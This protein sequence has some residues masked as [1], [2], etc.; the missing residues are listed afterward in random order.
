M[1]SSRH[2]THNKHL[3]KWRRKTFMG[4][5]RHSSE[6]PSTLYQFLVIFIVVGGFKVSFFFADIIIITY[7]WGGGR[8]TDGKIFRSMIS[9]KVNKEY[10]RRRFKSPWIT[11]YLCVMI[12]KWYYYPKSSK[13]FIMRDYCDVT[14]D[15]VRNNF[16]VNFPSNWSP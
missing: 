13:D 3:G 5:F 4:F 11:S 9:E 10:F 6:I 1:T 16:S 14:Y 8:K 2:P 15:L 7:I 12:H